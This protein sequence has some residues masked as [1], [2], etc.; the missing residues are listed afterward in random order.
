MLFGCE[1]N[2][3]D[4]FVIGGKFIVCLDGWRNAKYQA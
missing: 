4:S 3:L 1:A 2:R